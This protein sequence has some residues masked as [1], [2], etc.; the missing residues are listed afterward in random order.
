MRANEVTS[1]LRVDAM[2]LDLSRIRDSGGQ[3]TVV[4]RRSIGC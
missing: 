3:V 4:E 2:V 1:S